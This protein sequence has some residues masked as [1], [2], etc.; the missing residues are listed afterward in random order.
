MPAAA[1][2]HRSSPAQTIFEKIYIIEHVA[3]FGTFDQSD[4]QDWLKGTLPLSP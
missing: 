4:I 2:M 3:L 1:R